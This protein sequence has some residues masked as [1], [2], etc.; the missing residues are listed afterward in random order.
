MV[1]DG[2]QLWERAFIQ[3]WQQRFSADGKHL[4]AVVS[5]KYGQWT[6]AVDGVAWASSFGDMIPDWTFSPDG[7][8]VA[9]VF[10]AGEHWSLAVDG[11]RWRNDFAMA[12]N[13]VFSPDG[14]HLALRVE[15]QDGSHTIAVDDQIWSHA[16]QHAWDPVFSPDSEKVLIRC[17]EDGVYHRRVLAVRDLL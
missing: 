16:C 1:Q 2:E 14:N 3:T 15:L 10:K 11:R 6:M 17:V 8:R 5:P 4:V 9:A 7:T 13:P 12:F